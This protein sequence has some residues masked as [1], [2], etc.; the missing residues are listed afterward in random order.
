[1]LKAVYTGFMS[2]QQ[3]LVIEVILVG[4]APRMPR[5]SAL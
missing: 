4:I 3:A 1:M 5:K 2:H